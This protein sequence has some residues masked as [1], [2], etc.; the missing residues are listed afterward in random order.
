MRIST[1]LLNTSGLFQ[2]LKKQNELHYTQLQL[3]TQKR[4]LTPAD[5]PVAATGILELRSDL[6]QLEQFQSNGAI[7][8]A[9]N[10]LEEAVLTS[11]NEI[12]FRINE[13]FVSVGN[14]TFSSEELSSI[15]TELE[16]RYEELIGL[17]NTQD[18]SGDYLFSGFKNQT[19]AF[20]LDVA[21]NAI[22]NGDQGQRNLKISSNV[23]V[24]ISDSG[25]E[26]FVNIPNGNGKF[27][28][29][30]NVANTGGGIITP[31]N[32]SGPGNF[33]T[34][35]YEIRMTSDTTYDV[36][37]L[38]DSA[39]VQ[40]GTYEEFADITFA[41]ITV[42]LEGMPLNG[43]VFSVAPS[44]KQSIFETLEELMFTFDEFNFTEP[45]KALFRSRLNN[46]DGAFRAGR[47]NVDLIRGHIGSRLNAIEQENNAN[48]GIIL[49]NQL[50]LSDLEDLDV[51][52][53][54]SRLSQQ[55]AVLDAAQA[56]FVRVQNLTLFRFL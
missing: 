24:P 51:I 19:R 23:E 10:Q 33:V 28:V 45:G 18:S 49:N 44:Q 14:V 27:T 29:A 34:D 6:D 8:K 12:L 53:A 9:N 54:A 13:L 30:A 21:G 41:G 5:D 43:D 11:V 26:V 38:S 48:A 35:S 55:T 42:S 16:E 37:R 40:T 31:G 32:F 22:Y 7:A 2:I 46:L 15:N 20:S 25:Y 36:V 3:S 1:N 56:S 52:E 17:A 47:Q 39:T 50:A 4:F